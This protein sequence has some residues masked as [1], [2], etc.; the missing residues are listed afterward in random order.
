[1][2]AQ[3]R[4]L[5]GPLLTINLVANDRQDSRLGLAIARKAV[6]TAVQRNRVKRVIR[7]YFRQH[8]PE[9]SGYDCVFF[10]QP[11][12]ATATRQQIR[13]ALIDLWQQVRARC[14]T[15][16]SPQSESTSG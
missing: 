8:W 9:I 2:L 12:A 10:A 14:G 6:P 4:R 11:A 13:C 3:G 5:R 16:R 7:D 15:A 1:M